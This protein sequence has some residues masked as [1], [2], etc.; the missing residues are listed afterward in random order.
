MKFRITTFQKRF[1]FFHFKSCSKF[2]FRFWWFRII[3]QSKKIEKVVFYLTP[4]TKNDSS[5]DFLLNEE[6]TNK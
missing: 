2:L 3:I 6:I 4:K 5:L 1:T